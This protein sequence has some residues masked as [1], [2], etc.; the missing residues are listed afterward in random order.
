M[1]DFITFDA[2][3]E[4]LVWGDR[5]YTIL[6]LPGEVMDALPRGTKRIEGEFGEFPINLALTRAP[7][8]PATF[9]YTGAALLREAGLT[10]GE[11]F[12]ARIRPADP[13]YVEMPDDV[14]AA[15]RAAG[16]SSDWAA[17]SAGQRRGRLHAVSTA[18][19]AE[20]RARRIAALVANL[21]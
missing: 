18:K 11:V 5:T 6:T 16:R 17:L 12:E 1:T 9:V 21:T 13:D 4:P 7:V 10:P 14:S 8:T 2:R 3:I 19:R 15:L 20:T